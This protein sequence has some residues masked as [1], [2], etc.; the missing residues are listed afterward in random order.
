MFAS[1]REA[2]GESETTVEPGPLPQVL[3][4]LHGRYGEVFR[5]RLELCTVLVDGSSVSA[6]ADVRVLDGAEVAL[7]PPVSGGVSSALP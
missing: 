3:E 6:T 2:A 4:T 7:L 5:R 1:L